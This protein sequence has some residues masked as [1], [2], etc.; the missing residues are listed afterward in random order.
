MPNPPPPNRAIAELVHG[1]GDEDARELVGMFLKGFDSMLVALAGED[2]EEQRRAAHSLKSSARIVGLMELSHL[3]GQ[4]ETRLSG[5]EGAVASA[6]VSTA[7][8]KFD[9]DAPALR[10]FA[11]TAGS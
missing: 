10:A 4:L 8:K 6:D 7:R 3:M 5:A 11:T 1:L 9:E 2:R